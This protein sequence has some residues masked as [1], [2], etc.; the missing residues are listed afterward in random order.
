MNALHQDLK[1]STALVLTRD[2]DP[3]LS[4]E[5]RLFFCDCGFGMAATTQGRTIGGHFKDGY[6]AEIDAMKD[7]DVAATRAYWEKQAEERK[8]RALG[9][10]MQV[11]VHYAASGPGGGTLTGPLIQR[12]GQIMAGRGGGVSASPSTSTGGSAASGPL[13]KP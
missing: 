6:E 7:I 9:Q 11:A 10:T 12:L 13:F 3:A 1:P 8:P 5:Q 2:Y 4:D